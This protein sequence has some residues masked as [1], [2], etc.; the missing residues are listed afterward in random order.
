MKLEHVAF[1]VA[2]PAL[3]AE[4]YVKH[5]GMEI[6]FQRD[7]PPYTVFLADDS[8]QITIEFYLDPP[9]QVPDY[10]SMDPLLL[11]LAFISNDPTQEQKKLIAAGAT[12]YS[13]RITP[14]GT[15][16]VMLRD[17]WGLPV[18]LCKR[19]KPLLK[20]VTP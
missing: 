13:D 16:L 15:R 17:P 7:V 18:Q 10:A 8:G 6:V 11:H 4:W 12:L 2:A 1:N 19:V 20:N 9:G 14:D 5:L 3:A